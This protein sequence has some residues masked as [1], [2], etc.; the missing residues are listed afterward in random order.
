MHYHISDTSRAGMK[1]GMYLGKQSNKMGSPSQSSAS[2]AASGMWA[3]P[4]SLHAAVAVS[5]TLVSLTPCVIMHAEI[6][7]NH[8]YIMYVCMYVCMYVHLQHT[9]SRHT[10]LW[11]REG[12]GITL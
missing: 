6:R 9:V 2:P 1:G 4:T 3:C 11:Y 7:T 8:S 10:H 12:L 5:T